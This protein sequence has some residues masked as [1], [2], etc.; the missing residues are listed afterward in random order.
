MAIVRTAEWKLVSAP[1]EAESSVRRAMADLGLDPEGSMGTVRGKSK[2]ALL[3]NRW[4]ATVE[5]TVSRAA[6]G[7]VVVWHIDMAGTKHYSLLDEIAERV[8]D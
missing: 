1:E 6:V 8:G 3:K 2:A 7:S 4:A 5:A